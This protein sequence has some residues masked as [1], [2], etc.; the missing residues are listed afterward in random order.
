MYLKST[1]VTRVISP[2]SAG[3]ITCTMS[4]VC[5]AASH[6][7][8]ASSFMIKGILQDWIQQDHLTSTSQHWEDT[9]VKT[10]LLQQLEK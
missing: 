7:V 4:P 3:Y 8:A 2:A 5:L 10:C 9:G 1:D 6:P